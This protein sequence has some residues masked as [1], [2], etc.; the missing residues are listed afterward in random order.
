MDVNDFLDE[1]CEQDFPSDLGRKIRKDDHDP[2]FTQKELIE[3]SRLGVIC[4]DTKSWTYQLTMKATRMK[5][6]K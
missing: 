1:M 3:M 4:L 2:P 5:E 6:N